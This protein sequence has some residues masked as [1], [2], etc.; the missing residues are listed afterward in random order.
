[1][2]LV[3]GIGNIFHGDDAFGSE[4]AR[5]LQRRDWPEDVQVVDFGIRSFDLMYALMDGYEAVVL[6]DATPLGGA[7]GSLYLIEPELRD[8]DIAELE[9]HNMNPA[10]VLAAARQMGAEPKSVYVLGCEPEAL[11]GMGL[12][13]QVQGVMDAATGMIEE[14][15]H[16]I[17]TEKE[18]YEPGKAH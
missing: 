2:I 9:T 8:D 6:I 18:T 14:L 4:M 13:E 5:L 16:R 11:E 17:R 1:M 10:R 15:L 12:S 7:P 3:A